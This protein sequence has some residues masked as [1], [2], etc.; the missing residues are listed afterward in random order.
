V[1]CVDVVETAGAVGAAC[2]IAVEVDV[3]KEGVVVYCVVWVASVVL[4]TDVAV[5]CGVDIL[6]LLVADV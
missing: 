3:L 4:G 5:V 1:A 2:A 6:G